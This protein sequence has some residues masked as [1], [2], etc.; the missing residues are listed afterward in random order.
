MKQFLF[1]FSFILFPLIFSAQGIKKRTP[2]GKRVL[3]TDTSVLERMERKADSMINSIPPTDSQK[4]REDAE[5]NINAVV[6]LQNTQQDRKRKGAF[7]RIAIGV[8]L[9]V[10]LIIGLSRRKRKQVG[11][12]RS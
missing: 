8:A 9:L 6:E 12:K 11:E 10:V 3:I 1:L 7:I 4:I 2:D 5:R